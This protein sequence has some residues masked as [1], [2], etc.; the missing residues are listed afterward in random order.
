MRALHIPFY[1]VVYTL[2]SDRIGVG[3]ESHT[4][5]RA[6]TMAVERN[7]TMRMKK[8]KQR[9]REQKKQA[10][11]KLSSVV[12]TCCHEKCVLAAN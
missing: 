12:A 2:I 11:A 1:L 6:R 8:T 7:A 5:I 4:E 10:V 9:E 3:F